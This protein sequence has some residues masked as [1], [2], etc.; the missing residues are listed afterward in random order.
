MLALDTYKDEPSSTEVEP[1]PEFAISK[2]FT[3]EANSEFTRN[4]ISTFVN[5]DPQIRN[6]MV[7]V[8][9]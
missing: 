4:G 1:N 7:A 5:I 9:D 6:G 8:T 3:T 2:I